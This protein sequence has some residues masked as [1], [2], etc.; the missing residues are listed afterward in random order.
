MCPLLGQIETVYLY[1]LYS[2]EVNNNLTMQFLNI[3]VRLQRYINY[4]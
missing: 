2:F 3:P 4:A 1:Y